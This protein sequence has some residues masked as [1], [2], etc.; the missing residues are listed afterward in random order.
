MRIHSYWKVASYDF[1]KSSEV[2]HTP[3]LVDFLCVG[4]ITVGSDS[5]DR[6]IK[7]LEYEEVPSLQEGAFA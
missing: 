5:P 4:L 7:H 3:F 1:K 2:C 6:P